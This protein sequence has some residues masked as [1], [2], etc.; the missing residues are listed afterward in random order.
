MIVG[1]LLTIGGLLVLFFMAG[2]KVPTSVSP[3]WLLVLG[4]AAL[5]LLSLK[6]LPKKK[7]YMC[8]AKG[9]IGWGPFRRVCDRC[10]GDGLINRM[11]AN[12][13]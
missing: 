7:C 9:H 3:G 1:P 11:G 5:W 10:K 12:N 2:G 4:L 6:V 13:D 8:G